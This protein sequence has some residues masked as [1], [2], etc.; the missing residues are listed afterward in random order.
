VSGKGIPA[1]LFMTMAKT[2]LK[3]SSI[4]GLSPARCFDHV[5]KFLSQDNDTCM[6]VSAVYGTLELETGEVT[7]SNGGHNPPFIMDKSGN[8][9]IVDK[10]KSCVLG[11]D[12]KCYLES[13]FTLEPG[14]TIF[15]YTDGVTEAQNN[16]EEL[17]SEKRLG[18]LLKTCTG[19][20]PQEIVDKVLQEIYLFA[21]GAPQSDDITMIALQYNGIK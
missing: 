21:D 10:S 15:L 5:N 9:Q 13:T 16:A 11:L 3:A 1:A 14:S 7:Y 2:L 4:S 8:V 17:F 12:D 6:F 19:L 18:E 20:K